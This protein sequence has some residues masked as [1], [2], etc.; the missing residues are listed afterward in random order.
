MENVVFLKGLLQN[1]L[2]SIGFLRYGW[3]LEGVVDQSPGIRSRSNSG[4]Q[5]ARTLKKHSKIEDSGSPRPFRHAKIQDL[6]QISP[7]E[8]GD[9]P[10]QKGS[11]GGE[12]RSILK[13]QQ[14]TTTIPQVLPGIRFAAE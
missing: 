9:S 4:P 10:V 12:S 11:L 8:K 1:L 2:K 14:A 13:A 7:V 3:V 6:E 5:K